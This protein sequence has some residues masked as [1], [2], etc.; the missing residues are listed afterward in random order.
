MGVAVLQR[1]PFSKQINP[2]FM[3]KI[4]ITLLNVLLIASYARP[5]MGTLDLNFGN[6]GHVFSP[7]ISMNYNDIALQPDGKF[8]IAGDISSNGQSDFAILRYKA[9]GT[10][11]ISFGQGGLVTT[12]FG[13][14]FEAANTVAIQPDG[15]IIAAG[16]TGPYTGNTSMAISR[17]NSDGSLDLGFSDDGMLTLPT[18]A[19][20]LGGLDIEIQPD[21]KIVMVGESFFTDGFD[22]VIYRFNSD[23]SFDLSFG[24][25]GM[26]AVDFGAFYDLASSVLIQPDG[27]IVVAGNSANAFA[28][29]RLNNNGSLDISFE[30]DGKLTTGLNDYYGPRHP[31]IVLQPDGKI[32]LSGS[33]TSLSDFYSDCSIIRYN[34]DGSLDFSFSDDGILV[35]GFSGIQETINDVE[36]QADGKILV[37]GSTSIN[38]SSDFLIRRYNTGG[39]PDNSF[40][41]NG[42]VITDFGTPEATNAIAL[43]NNRIYAAG[44]STQHGGLIAAY[45]GGNDCSISPQLQVNVADVYALNPGGNA[46]TIYL[47]YGPSSLTLTANTAG[48]HPAYSY[49]WELGGTL[50]GTGPTLT[51]TQSNVGV[52]DYK[53][54]VTDSWGCTA[55]FVK[56][57]QVV[58]VRC[59]SK[60]DMVLV[61]H[62][63]K[64]GTYNTMCIRTNLVQTHL[65]HSDYLG[66]CNGAALMGEN[67]TGTSAARPAIETKEMF[68]IK[69]LKIS[70]NPATHFIDVQWTTTNTAQST[71]RI[72]NAEGRVVRTLTPKGAID[73]QRISLNGLAKGI[74]VLVLKTGSDQQVS[75]FVIQ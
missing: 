15:K 8:I 47:G 6:N 63:N 42:E 31:A 41:N 21:G 56:T 5:Q 24:Q 48:G 11:D 7:A 36:I 68:A 53:I 71:I 43:T 16:V 20:T 27:K 51:V 45:R 28:I 38:G 67:A 58:D 46:N 49:S 10:L 65:D 74:Y 73:N 3:K 54:I 32:I 72:L 30:G 52:Y 22:F 2:L 66:N 25:D 9:K 13:N 55:E 57:I 39:I 75:K 40:N 64:N 44:I 35:F 14:E 19:G 50:M 33:I 26:V 69:G 34:V 4:L 17:Y 29:A 1:F 62:R 37:A 70:P 12:N 60:N 61:C 18:N 23:G 59:G